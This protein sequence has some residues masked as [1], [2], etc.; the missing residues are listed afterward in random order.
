MKRTLA[1]LLCL[2]L[3]AALCPFASAEEGAPH[4][5][6][7]I[8]FDRPMHG[9]VSGTLEP[10]NY[11][12]DGECSLLGHVL[13]EGEVNLCL[14]GHPIAVQSS[15]TFLVCDGGV[16]NIYDCVGTGLIGYYNTQL[17]NHPLTVDPGGTA[18]LY[19]G[20]L[21]GRDG[22]NA[23]NNRG[24]TVSI[25]GGKVESGWDFQCAVLNE[26]VLNLYGGELIG[27]IGISQRHHAVLNFYGNEFSVKGTRKAL[28]YI[29]P[30][31]PLE[32]HTPYYRWRS[33]PEGE[34]TDSTETPFVSVD[35]YKYVEFAPLTA[36]IEYET[37]GGTLG[38]DAPREYV[39][40]VGCALPEPDAPDGCAFVGWY[41]AAEG[42]ERLE[43]V[44]ADRAGDLT[45]YAR[46]EPLPSPTPE[47]MPTV[48]PTVEPA[49]GPTVEPTPAGAPR[50]ALPAHLQRPLLILA[51]VVLAVLLSAL[52]AILRVVKKR[53]PSDGE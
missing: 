32:I 26:G 45:L 9:V 50:A 40:G 41:D 44:G 4:E 46:Y 8:V 15:T 35:S 37:D 2:L 43:A 23:V 7:G 28:Q 53:P 27:Y 19:G 22:S 48:E 51:L 24:G 42:G 12:V 33:D 11:Y 10:G 52:Y 5:C 1:L 29:E 3:L 38:G 36:Q 30:I 18:N 13:I 47:P 25:Y 34:F 16:F 17:H 6:S 21:Y 20:W 14:N 39:C 49:S 31:S